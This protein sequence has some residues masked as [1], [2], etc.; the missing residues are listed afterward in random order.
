MKFKIQNA[1]GKIKNFILGS[2]SAG[3]YGMLAR[4]ES[5]GELVK[6]AAALQ[7]AGYRR[8]DAHSPYPVHG[9]DAAMGSRFSPIPFLVLG[10]GIT[11]ALVGLALQVFVHVF[12]YPLIFSGK[13][14]WSI[15]AFI[16]VMFE[17]TILFAAF[18]AVFGMFAVNGLPMLYH[19][20]LKSEQFLKVTD[21]AFFI[22]IEARDRQFDPA[23]TKVLL[24]SLG[25]TNVELVEG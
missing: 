5:A 21:D 19:P 17:L 14:M 3:P 7:R 1:K 11:G 8:F 22:S 25:G 15:P 13:P 24:E 12:D 2:P 18:G 10:G 16:P 6:A 9:L 4:F 20:L 23:Q